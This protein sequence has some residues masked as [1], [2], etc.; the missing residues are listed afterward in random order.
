[1]KLLNSGLSQID[2]LAGKE[3]IDVIC[4]FTDYQIDV[5][6]WIIKSFFD[7]GI[8]VTV[9]PPGIKFID[10]EALNFFCFRIEWDYQL[11]L[12]QG[13]SQG[14]IGKRKYE[15]LIESSGEIIDIIKKGL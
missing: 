13:F 2:R 10:S 11:L 1:M 12:L 9:N 14:S 3:H 4:F 5:C 7:S 6:N 15:S 8:Q